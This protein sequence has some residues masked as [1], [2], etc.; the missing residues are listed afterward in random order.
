[1]LIEHPREAGFDALKKFVDDDGRHF[2]VIQFE[3]DSGRVFRKTQSDDDT[4]IAELVPHDE[5]A[6]EC[7]RMIA[8]ATD[9]D[10][11]EAANTQQNLRRLMAGE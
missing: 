9:F 5:S 4:S 11:E 3:N 10:V 6:M 1:V 2:Y 8:S 7:M